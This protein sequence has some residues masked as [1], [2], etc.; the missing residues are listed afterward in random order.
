MTGVDFLIEVMVKLL[1]HCS[2]LVQ[3]H[4]SQHG[5]WAPDKFYHCGDEPLLKVS[6]R[7]VLLFLG[8]IYGTL[9]I[10]HREHS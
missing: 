7:G 4:T 9:N 5:K 2:C 8:L 1:K 3:S 10:Y 6:E